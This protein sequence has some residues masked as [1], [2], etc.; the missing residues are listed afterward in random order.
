MLQC[1]LLIRLRLAP[2]PPGRA[3]FF[4]FFYPDF[5]PPALGAPPPPLDAALSLLFVTWPWAGF[6]VPPS[7]SDLS[8][9]MS[10]FAGEASRGLVCGDIQIS[11]KD[12]LSFNLWSLS[13]MI[14]GRLTSLPLSLPAVACSSSG[15]VEEGSKAAFSVAAAA[16]SLPD[17]EYSFGSGL[18]ESLSWASLRARLGRV[19]EKGRVAVM[20]VVVVGRKLGLALTIERRKSCIFAVGIGLDW[21]W[22]L[23]LVRGCG[24]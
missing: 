21:C 17:L 11:K 24:V 14:Q 7:F 20:R 4:C 12:L 10:W 6:P 18:R 3:H 2:P 15:R 1:L 16:S 23:V 8:L 22:V 13:G 9:L 19:E 5:E